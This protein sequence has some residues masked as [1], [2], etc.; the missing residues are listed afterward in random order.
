MKRSRNILSAR[1]R[2]CNFHV[3]L[4]VATLLLIGTAHAQT[5]NVLYAFQYPGP[6]EPASGVTIDAAGNL[7]GTISATYAG[8]GGVFKLSN[9]NRAWTFSLLFSFSYA[10]GNTPLAPP[11]FGPDG[12][13]YG[14]TYVGGIGCDLGC[15]NVY[16]L[17]PPVSICRTT[18]CYWTASTVWDFY[19][20]PD[21]GI[22]PVFVNP[23]FDAAGNI[24]GTTSDDWPQSGLSGG[25]VF[26]LSRSNGV[27]SETILHQFGNGTDGSGPESGLIRDSNG[28]LYG[29]T[30]DGGTDASCNSGRG[31]GTIY[32]LSPSGSGWTERVL[33][34]FQGQNDG[35]SPVGGLVMDAADNLYGTT[36]Q[37][38]AD[39]GGTIFELTPSTGNWTLTTLYSFPKTGEPGAFCWGP[40]ANLLLD[41]AGNLYGT[42]CTNG[43]YGYGAVFKLAHANGSW[44][45]SSL[46]D[47]TN[48][49]DGASPIG[50]PAFDRN[51]NIFGTAFKGGVNLEGTVWEITP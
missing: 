3:L 17:R 29:T 16:N 31:C 22:W 23:L 1:M 8:E 40:E 21:G 10:N 41:R 18:L 32:E 19:S 43:A 13:L 51:G 47:F 14:T 42:T 5:F 50:N 12:S 48:G 9:R 6:V 25:N 35:D 33:Y 44:S 4:L 20:T 46:H 26:E 34:S 15:G 28:N 38:G 7:Y 2:L 11:A 49:N 39:G 36:V 24:Y 45:Y 37:D 27:W 30:T